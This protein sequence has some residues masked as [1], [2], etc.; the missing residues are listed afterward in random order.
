MFPAKSLYGNVCSE[1]SD[2]LVEN[3]GFY[4]LFCCKSTVNP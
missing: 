3:E 2:K 4:L 1:N